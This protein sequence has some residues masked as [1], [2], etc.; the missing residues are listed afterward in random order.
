M[1]PLLTLKEVSQTTSVLNFLNPEFCN[2]GEKKNTDEW[3]MKE[4]DIVYCKSICKQLNNSEAVLG[5][6][7]N[8][9]QDDMFIIWVYVSIYIPV[10]I[11]QDTFCDFFKKLFLEK[12]G[13]T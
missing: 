1:L 4:E 3:D 11:T 12:I 2:F 10:V 13:K 8:C 5:N 7:N 6:H 9:S